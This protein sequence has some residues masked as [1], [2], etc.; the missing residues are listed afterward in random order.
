MRPW[1][2]ALLLASGLTLGALG[3]RLATPWLAGDGDDHPAA[4]PASA[5]GGGLHVDAVVQRQ[6]G[7]RLTPLTLASLPAASEGFARALDLSPLAAIAAEIT[8]A[9]AAHDA[10]ARE[11]ARLAGLVAADAG[12]A[13]RDLDAARG[14]E[15][16]DAARLTLAC[17]RPALE[18]GAGLARLGCAAIPGLA[19]EAAQGRLAVLRLDF[20]DGPVSQGASVAVDLAPAHITVRT[21][22]PAI[23][24]DTQ[25]QS[26]GALALV[27][28]EAASAAGVGRVLA[29][30]RAT[31]EHRAGLV[32]PREA[33][34]RADGTQQVYRALGGDGF[35]RVS[36][37]AAQPVVQGWF[38]PL[39][40]GL[41]PGDR[42]V[43]A[44]AGTLLGIERSASGGQSGD[45]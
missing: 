18:F 17:Q 43:V 7:L 29:A 19:R 11:A 6:A 2:G 21:L 33:I 24:G 31:G 45:D 41:R 5:V 12:A 38:L 4:A 30:H 32:I 27:R 14:Q 23:T 37:D 22:G 28:G 8:A 36:I 13:R 15:G 9:T 35:E 1:Q 25:L 10:S 26:A 3:M 44:G 34:V 16:Q 42:L 39:G 20:P 40:H